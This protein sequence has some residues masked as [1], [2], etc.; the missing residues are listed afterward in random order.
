M[1]KT[2]TVARPVG[3]REPVRGTALVTAVASGL[4]LLG[5]KL[6]KLDVTTAAAV[7]TGLAPVLV[8]EIGRRFAFAPATVRAREAQLR[9]SAFGHQPVA[10]LAPVGR[11][12]EW[13]RRYWPAGL[14][15]A[16]LAFVGP[17]TYAIITTGEGGTLSEWTRDQLGTT[18]GETTAGW[19]AM[20][21]GVGLFAVWWSG[22]LIRWWPW[23][24]KNRRTPV[25]E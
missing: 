18:Q 1:P 22:H 9:A 19:W 5:V 21:A 4:T 2:D 17:E 13:L 24:R 14:L 15:V 16:L 11:D 3:G 6:A 25:G 10:P 7:A 20:T 23:E 8:G 12:P